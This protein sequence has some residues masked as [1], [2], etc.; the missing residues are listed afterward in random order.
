MSSEGPVFHRFGSRVRYLLA[1]VEAWTSASVASEL[2][3]RMCSR[4]RPSRCL[5][6]ISKS[7]ILPLPSILYVGCSYDVAGLAVNAGGRQFKLAGMPNL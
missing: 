2:P 3:R 7:C 6:L 1:D 4:E 5:C